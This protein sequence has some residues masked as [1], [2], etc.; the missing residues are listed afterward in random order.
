MTRTDS[1]PALKAFATLRFEGDSLDVSTLSEM[2]GVTPTLAY[3]KGEPYRLGKRGA[4]KIGETGY[5]LLNTKDRLGTPE[6]SDHIAFIVDILAG[7]DKDQTFDR[8]KSAVGA[9]SLST[10]VTLF[11]FGQAGAQ[12]PTIDPRLEGLVRRLRGAIETDFVT[13]GRDPE[14][15]DGRAA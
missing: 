5:W 9:A 3:R 8:L 7:A 12:P 4:E 14:R 2:L 15:I 6:L 11:W 13:K 10:L 1:S